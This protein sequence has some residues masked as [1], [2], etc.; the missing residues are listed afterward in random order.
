MPGVPSMAALGSDAQGWMNALGNHTAHGADLNLDSY[1]WRPHCLLHFD[2][3]LS[4]GDATRPVIHLRQ[5]VIGS[6]HLLQIPLFSPG[7]AQTC[8]ARRPSHQKRKCHPRLPPQKLLMLR[9]QDGFL[10]SRVT[11]ISRAELWPVFWA[12]SLPPAE[13]ICHMTPVHGNQHLI[14]LVTLAAKDL[15]SC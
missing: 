1:L 12:L 5:I 11:S 14:S 7:Q 2:S 6:V 13:T 4:P 9:D 15:N 8:S 3:S 10:D